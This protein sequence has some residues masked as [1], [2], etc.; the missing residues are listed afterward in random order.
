MESDERK[1]HDITGKE[2][3]PGSIVVVSINNK[4]KIALV[5]DICWN[6]I[7]FCGK[8]KEYPTIKLL[9]SGSRWNRDIQRSVGL[10]RST[11]T[12][13]IS[14]IVCID[15][16]EYIDN[17]KN[18]KTTDIDSDIIRLMEDEIKKRK[19]LKLVS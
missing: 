13:N 14:S 3:K 7:K 17:V 6:Q 18:G 11:Q 1:V 15:G 10:L 12:N 5:K 16:E 19:K 4:N 8:H 2:I 9:I